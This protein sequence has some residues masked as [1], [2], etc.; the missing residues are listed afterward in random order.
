MVHHQMPET[1]ILPTLAGQH[2]RALM[3]ANNVI[4][5]NAALMGE[6]L[7]AGLQHNREM[8]ALRIRQLYT[9]TRLKR[10]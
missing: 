7:L 4:M 8:P 2:H 6:K 9:I 3:L 10:A 5:R 1:Q